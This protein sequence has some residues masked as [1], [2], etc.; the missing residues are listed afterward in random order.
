MTRTIGTLLLIVA[1][2]LQPVANAAPPAGETLRVAVHLNAIRDASR[3]D[4]EVALKVWAEELID[5]LAIQARIDFYNNMTDMRRAMDTGAAN[6][7]IA[8]GIDLLRH[9]GPDDLTDGFGAAAANEDSMLLLVRSD[10]GIRDFHELAGKR[11]VLLDHNELSDLLLETRCLRH[12]RSG[13]AQAGISVLHE[14][15]SQQEVLQVFFGKADAALVRGYPYILATELNPQIKS[16]VRILERIAIYP[17]ALGLFSTRVSSAFREHV[18]RKLPELESH[19]RGRQLLEVMQ[20]ERVG[21]FPK[22][23]LEPIRDLL[24]EHDRLS[25]QH[26]RGKVT[27]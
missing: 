19:P 24:R 23:A 7:V 10:S 17:S 6:F 22:S 12:F 15:S 3:A 21:R 2:L 13:C 9:F 26:S 5:A 11:I 4:M 27:R 1:G 20:T 18:I 16:R 14:T 8:D 25:R